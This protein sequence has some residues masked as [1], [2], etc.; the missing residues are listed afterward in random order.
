MKGIK[1]IILAYNLNNVFVLEIY[2][3]E[4][5]NKTCKFS[6]YQYTLKIISL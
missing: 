4:V 3:L 2:Q 6:L 5:V 1:F